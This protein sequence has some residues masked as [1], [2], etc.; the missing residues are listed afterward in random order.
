MSFQGQVYFLFLFQAH[1][2]V[3]AAGSP[4]LSSM[5]CCLPDNTHMCVQL[6]VETQT[7]ALELIIDFFYTGHITLSSSV[8]QMVLQLAEMFQV[9][10][11]VD[12][13][14]T[15]HGNS[16]TPFSRKKLTDVESVPKKETAINVKSESS[17]VKR[18]RGRGLKVGLKPS[19]GRSR[20]SETLSSIQ[21]DTKQALRV[22]LRTGRGRG[23]GRGR[24]RG[25]G[26]V[27][28]RGRS[29]SSPGKMKTENILDSFGQVLSPDSSLH[30]P[31]PGLR[32]SKATP[33]VSKSP[34]EDNSAQNLSEDIHH[35]VSGGNS[36]NRDKTACRGK[37]GPKTRAEIQR[38]YRERKL[39]GMTE[40]QILEHKAKEANRVRMSNYLRNGLPVTGIRGPRGHRRRGMGR[41]QALAVAL[42]FGRALKKEVDQEGCCR[43]TVS[44]TLAR[45][46]VGKDVH[47]VEV[48][49][50][51]KLI[52]YIIFALNTV[53]LLW[54]HC[55]FSKQG[56]CGFQ[57]LLKMQ[58]TVRCIL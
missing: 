53:H 1:K 13:C 55:V 16:K 50:A 45:N 5:A 15:F 18:G 52:M 41:D 34:I 26:R 37:K 14:K 28:C 12:F 35:L 51:N 24:R 47:K 3:L 40:E 7:T 19:R 25:H 17:H 54:N 4:V 30:F 56:I 32:T 21:V 36:T 44:Q 9:K 46:V 10:S 31:S 39:A 38:A 49:K 11:L 57:K 33:C 29:S 43:A 8:Y 48:F 2:L 22:S 58:V 42:R 20:A 27:S 23:R 6:P